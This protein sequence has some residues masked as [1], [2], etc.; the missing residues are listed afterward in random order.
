MHDFNATCGERSSCL[1][2]LDKLES[3]PEDGRRRYLYKCLCQLYDSE[4][5]LSGDF[6]HSGL[7]GC[8]HLQVYWQNQSPLRL[9]N[10][11][12]S[13]AKGKQWFCF[14]K[15]GVAGIRYWW[16]W[17]EY[18]LRIGHSLLLSQKINYKFCILHKQYN[19]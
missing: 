2:P 6:F 4:I 15:K 16:I 19:K 1:P 13:F 12:I 5:T 17:P 14:L 10:G 11:D 18:F 8:G 7:R 9:G 3:C